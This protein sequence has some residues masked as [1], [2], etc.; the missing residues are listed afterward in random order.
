MPTVY[1]VAKLYF[2]ASYALV[3]AIVSAFIILLIDRIG[4]REFVVCRSP[5]VISRLFSCD[6]CLGFWVSVVLSAALSLAVGDA[7]FMLIPIMSTPV[8][9][10]LL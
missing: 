6:F 3:I 5:K 4:L 8:T 7:S 9:R 2:I 1:F 10:I